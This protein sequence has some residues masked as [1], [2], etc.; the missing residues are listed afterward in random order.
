[1]LLSARILDGVGS[2]NDFNYVDQ[3]EF[4]AG[5]TAR[6]YFQL[7]DLAKD[8]AVVGFKPA[9]RRYMP[10]SGATL[11]V[12]LD[13]IDDDKQVIRAAVQAFPTTDPSIWYVNVL[14]S[15]SVR[16]TVDMALQL[17]EGGVIRYGRAAA[18]VAASNQGTL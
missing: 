5:D 6:V 14:A 11:Q 10:A 8:K 18:A 9:G 16:G 4:T 1:M 12:T 3:A 15:D 17:T 2:V 13:N 7:V